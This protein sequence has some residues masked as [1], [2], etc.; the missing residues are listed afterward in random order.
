MPSPKPELTVPELAKRSYL[1]PSQ[2]RQIQ[3]SVDH[4][5]FMMRDPET[6]EVAVPNTDRIAANLDKDMRMLQEGTP[7]EYDSLTKNKLNALRKKLEE[8]IQRGMPTADMMERSIPN[9]ID[10]HIWWEREN[11]Q[12]VAAWKAICRTLDPHNDEPNFTNIARLRPSTPPVGNPR[13]YWQGFDAISWEDQIEDTLTSELDDEVYHLFLELK[14][15]DWT[16]AGICKELAF[17]NEMYEVAMERLRTS[18]AGRRTAE[19]LA[20]PAPSPR[21]RPPTGDPDEDE[22]EEEDEDEDEELPDVD[23]EEAEDIRIH[24]GS[25]RGARPLPRVDLQPGAYRPDPW[26]D[27]IQERLDALGLEVLQF[28]KLTRGREKISPVHLRTMMKTGLVGG[29]TISAQLKAKID[30]A[31]DRIERDSVLLQSASTSTPLQRFSD[32][33]DALEALRNGAA[34]ELESDNTHNTETVETAPRGG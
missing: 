33:R 17:S 21:P 16:K 32:T 20:S 3:E 27:T 6:R 1:V 7:P 15:L 28:T 34:W 10:L 23:E 29:K 24:A 25:L 8:Q 2:R 5:Q 11:T 4:L 26:C 14:L 12:R 9:N 31:F 13:K 22:D 19:S 18:R 30:Q